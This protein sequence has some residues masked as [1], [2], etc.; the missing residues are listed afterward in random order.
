METRTCQ[1][2]NMQYS[3]L[4]PA[5]YGWWKPNSS[6]L[7]EH[8]S[9]YCRAISPAPTLKKT[10]LFYLIYLS[11]FLCISLY[12][13][14]TFACWFLRRSEVIVSLYPLELELTDSCA[15][16]GCCLLNLD[17]QEQLVLLT[18][19]PNLQPQ[20]HILKVTMFLGPQRMHFILPFYPHTLKDK[21]SNYLLSPF[22]K[23][24]LLVLWEL[25]VF[26]CIHLPFPNSFRSI[27]PS[28][29]TELCVLLFFL[30]QGRF[31]PHKYY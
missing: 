13:C 1:I 4:W 12:V 23:L 15:Y 7:K 20:H 2:C 18:T 28:S 8:E 19:D 24:F 14:A 9:H 26:D 21:S 16:L 31:V 29:T 30:H 27:T 17:L 22:L 11:V 10:N 3:C 5:W 25:Y 6:P